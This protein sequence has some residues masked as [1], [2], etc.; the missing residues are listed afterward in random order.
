MRLTYVH[1]KNMFSIED[2]KLDFND[3]GM[4]LLDGWNYDLNSSNGAGKTSCFNAVTYAIWD[5]VPRKVTKTEL[6]RRGCNKSSVK[7]GFYIGDNLFEV[8]RCR[9]TKVLYWKNKE[10]V[11]LSQEEFEKLVDISYTQF[12]ICAYSAQTNGKKFLLLNDNEKKDFLLQVLQ[13]NKF[14]DMKL[15]I[16]TKIKDII[17]AQDDLEKKKISIESKHEAYKEQLSTLVNID[18]V[19]ATQEN[20]LQ[21]QQE[22][23]SKLIMPQDENFEETIQKLRD[24]RSM[25]MGAIDN[26][27]RY[28]ETIETL[29]LQIRS[30]DTPSL[31]CPECGASI[32][33]DGKNAHT[34]KEYSKQIEQFNSSIQHKI[35]QLTDKINAIPNNV[36]EQIEKINTAITKV[37]QNKVRFQN[38]LQEFTTCKENIQNLI[39]RINVRI[40]TL[41]MRKAQHDALISKISQLDNQLATIDKQMT[42]ISAA[43]EAY[44]A[45]RTVVMPTGAPAYILD[46]A[47]D[48]FNSKMGEYLSSVW[49]SATYQLKTFKET[50]A[51]EIRAKMADYLIIDGE[52]R[53]IGS[54][55]GGEM[56]CLMVLADLAI[57]FTAASISGI[58]INPLILDE[59]FEA[60]DAANRE[61]MLNLI[62]SLAGNRE[63]WVIDHMG[64]SK[65]VFT[66]VVRVEKRSGISSVVI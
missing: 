14:N 19:I 1:I 16:D 30:L 6:V 5:K 28:T 23:L 31:S 56:R 29:K 39:A 7:V 38:R 55:S 24:R 33:M 12:L 17:K 52:E 25:L 36:E 22:Q 66:K 20:L 64:E 47:V 11:N 9:P 10:K 45:A 2:A 50:K 51:G 3:S 57:M 26:R 59:P 40:D 41:K 4:V 32:H 61:K 48:I 63:V 60:L 54:L 15:F 62:S 65:A 13:L 27:T 8:E 42:K 21:E 34:T 18:K 53:S 44:Q 49:P 37:T 58:E 35:C 43:L 46:T